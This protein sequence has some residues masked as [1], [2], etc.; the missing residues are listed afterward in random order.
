MFRLLKSYLLVLV[1]MPA[2]SASA[3]DM[4]EQRDILFKK[5]KFL[6][7][8]KTYIEKKAR[9]NPAWKDF[10]QAVNQYLNMYDELVS[11][12]EVSK[13][14][15]AHLSGLQTQIDKVNLSR[16]KRSRFRCVLHQA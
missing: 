10:S 1:F 8:Q 15:E 16:R 5:A 2:M 7:D 12:S 13:L 14:S 9:K 4:F 3:D 11:D 6:R